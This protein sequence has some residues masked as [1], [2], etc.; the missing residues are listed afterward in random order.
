MAE[1]L[2]FPEA[3]CRS[4]NMPLLRI[5]RMR[6]ATRTRSPVRPQPPAPHSAGL[7]LAGLMGALE[8]V[9]IGVDPLIRKT[10]ALADAD[11]AQWI[12]SVLKLA[13]AVRHHSPHSRT[14]DRARREIEDHV[15]KRRK[16][17]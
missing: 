6:P 9:G 2:D 5:A 4:M 14:R 7:E 15:V 17:P 16:V 13:L 12:L 11:S 10:V 1:N 8:A 3:S